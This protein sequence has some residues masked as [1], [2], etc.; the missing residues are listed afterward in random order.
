MLRLLSYA[1]RADMLSPLLLLPA[2]D[3]F[4]CRLRLSSDDFAFAA[5]LPFDFRRHFIFRYAAR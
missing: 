5:S 3:A 4:A 1:M 2:F